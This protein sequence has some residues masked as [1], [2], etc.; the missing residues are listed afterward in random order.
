MSSFM[1]VFISQVGIAYEPLLFYTI[2][3]VFLS[4]INITIY[5]NKL[6]IFKQ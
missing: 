2:L 1:M 6:H 5:T 4:V 3:P